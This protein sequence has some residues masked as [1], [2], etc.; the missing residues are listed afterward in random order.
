MQL[1]W[2]SFV[3]F[4]LEIL[5]LKRSPFLLFYR[6]NVFTFVFE[7]LIRSLKPIEGVRVEFS[8][9]KE[10]IPLIELLKRNSFER[11]T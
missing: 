2:L 3:V 8:P 5:L 7:L 9:S 11:L 1:N 4:T 10:G 6:K